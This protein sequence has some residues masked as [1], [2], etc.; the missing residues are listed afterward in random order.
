M[1]RPGREW[2]GVADVAAHKAL[3][4]AIYERLEMGDVAPLIEALHDDFVWRH[5]AKI[6][7][8]KFAGEWTGK[9]DVLARLAELNDE[10]TGEEDRLWVLCRVE[11]LNLRGETMATETA[12]FYRFK[13]GKIIAFNEIL[14][15]ALILQQMGRLEIQGGGRGMVSPLK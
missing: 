11:R 7:T 9:E 8:F 14:D 10:M 13:D 4:T 12:Q 2:D 6:G 3:I 1:P 15:T 5:H